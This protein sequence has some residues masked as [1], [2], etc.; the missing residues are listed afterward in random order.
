MRKRLTLRRRRKTEAENPLA[1]KTIKAA[2]RVVLPE[3][4][5]EYGLK[6]NPNLVSGQLN[7]SSKPE[8]SVETDGD[9]ISL[10][11]DTMMETVTIDLQKP[12]DRPVLHDE[13]PLVSNM[14]FSR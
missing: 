7:Q 2:P 11:N 6:K 3:A 8:L 4:T 12:K 10:R 13:G 9:N 14:G 5:P 1:I